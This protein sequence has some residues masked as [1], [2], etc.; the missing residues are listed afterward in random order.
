MGPRPP[1]AFEVDA[2]GVGT[3][4][5]GLRP[6]RPPLSTIVEHGKRAATEFLDGFDLG[7]YRNTFAATVAAT[8]PA[9]PAAPLART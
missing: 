5:F 6:D 1:G 2:D 7:A 9:P 3:T 8:A 4:D